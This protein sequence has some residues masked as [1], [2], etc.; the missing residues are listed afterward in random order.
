MENFSPK[1]GIA[2]PTGNYGQSNRQGFATTNHG[3]IRGRERRQTFVGDAYNKKDLPPRAEGTMAQSSLMR[4]S[5]TM[6]MDNIPRSRSQSPD[7]YSDKWVNMKLVNGGAALSSQMDSLST[8]MISSNPTRRN[9]TPTS[10]S[11]S[12]AFTLVDFEDS[13]SAAMK[14]NPN[15][16]T[17]TTH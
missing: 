6:S 10:G 17:P 2:A 5:G 9:V 12:P 14:P 16:E 7:N 13:L 1:L 4:L 11:S 15:R 3:T 8:Q